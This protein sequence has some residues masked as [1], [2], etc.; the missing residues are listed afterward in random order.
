MVGCGGVAMKHPMQYIINH[1]FVENKLISKL[2]D[3]IGL[4]RIAAMDYDDDDYDQMLQLIGYSTS[5]IPYRDESKYKITDEGA[6]PEEVFEQE[7]KQLKKKMA[8]IMA[9]LFNIHEGDLK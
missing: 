1:R 6:K 9:E 4:N 2:V 7:L 3:E 8:P 5:G